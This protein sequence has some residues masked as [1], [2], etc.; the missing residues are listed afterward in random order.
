V[1]KKRL[2]RCNP[3]KI[4]KN[5]PSGIKVILCKETRLKVGDMVYQYRRDDGI[6]EL[7]PESVMSPEDLKELSQL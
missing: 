4:V 1:P 6:I 7:V 3:Y 5:G 2:L